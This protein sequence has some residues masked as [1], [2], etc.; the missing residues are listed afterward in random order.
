MVFFDDISEYFTVSV[1]V[2]V[3]EDYNKQE[4]LKQKELFIIKETFFVMGYF[5]CKV[6][7]LMSLV[8]CNGMNHC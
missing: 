5:W 8:T 2:T 4:T 6:C 1:Q 3:N 7:R